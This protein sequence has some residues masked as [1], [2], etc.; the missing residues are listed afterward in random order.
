MPETWS[1]LAAAA[2]E[3]LFAATAQVAAA[4]GLPPPDRGA[5]LAIL[6]AAVLLAVAAVRGAADLRLAMNG[7]RTTG[8]VIGRVADPD[9]PDSPR[10][11][12]T[13]AQGRERRFRSEL[14]CTATTGAVG[15]EVAV[16][17][18]PAAP[19]RAREAGRMGAL[20]RLRA[21]QVAGAVLIV[22]VGYWLQG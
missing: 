21:M 9:G 3:R 2:L 5:A 20:A 11:A 14:A 18:D 10:I 7:T 17:Y 4:L 12:F 16:I 22:V 8:R 1:A 13:D 15:Q 19:R 6:A